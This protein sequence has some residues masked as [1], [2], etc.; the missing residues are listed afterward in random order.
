MP[1]YSQ[2]HE[3]LG[4]VYLRMAVRAYEPASRA[5]AAGE[6]SR[7]KLTLARELLARV[8]PGA[9][10]TPIPPGGPSTAAPK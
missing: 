9:P 10:V 6:A 1:S 7:N 3:N 8:V 4:D 5:T 2:A